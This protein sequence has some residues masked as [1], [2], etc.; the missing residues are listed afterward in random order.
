MLNHSYGRIIYI[1]EAVPTEALNGATAHGQADRTAR[2][3]RS[4]G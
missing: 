3:M 1:F 4:P 2:A